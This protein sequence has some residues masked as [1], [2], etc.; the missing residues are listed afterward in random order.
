MSEYQVRP[1]I[2]RDAMAIADIY[3]SAVQAAYKDL[4]PD[5]QLSGLYA[6]K[7]Q[8]F[9]REAIEMGEPQIL[10]ATEGEQV[11]GFVGFDRSRDKG[12]PSTMGEIWLIY[13]TPEKWSTGA[14]LA[15]WDAARDGLEDE[16][17]THV[18]LWLPLRNERALR[19]HEIAGFKRELNSA[20]T[21]D[22]G[23][24]KIESIRLKRAIG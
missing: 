6:S 15:L 21:V 8:G 7:R 9:W 14:G 19:F 10:V 23:G 5:D 18:S 4:V 24:V 11:V 13:V 17:C 20:K 1:A 2:P 3:A 12:T 22:V 16:G